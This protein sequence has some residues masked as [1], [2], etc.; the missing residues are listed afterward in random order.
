M[1]SVKSPDSAK[2]F[3]EARKWGEVMAEHEQDDIPR[4]QSFF[5]NYLSL[6][7]Y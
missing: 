4:L 7:K 1:Q 6:T 5:G 2:N 3:E